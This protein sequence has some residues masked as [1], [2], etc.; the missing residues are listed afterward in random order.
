M[1][2]NRYNYA[3]KEYIWAHIEPN[4][5]IVAAC[6]PTYAPILPGKA[7]FEKWI[8]ILRSF[9][10]LG[11]RSTNS[12]ASRSG[13]DVRKDHNTGSNSGLVLDSKSNG[14]WQKLDPG[15]LDGTYEHSVD[16]AGVPMM[17]REDLG[18]LTG[19]ED[20]EAGSH[21]I[22]PLKIAVTRE[23]GYDNDEVH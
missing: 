14:K 12:Y 21:G 1:Q 7:S 15:S 9:T 20:I 13:R 19:Q 5:S 16:I 22:A 8:D 3:T 23:F 6:L 11:S 17:G 4:C 10:S 18:A 2:G